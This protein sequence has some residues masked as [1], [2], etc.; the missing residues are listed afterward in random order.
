MESAL[1]ILSTFGVVFLLLTITVNFLTKRYPRI[2]GD[3]YIQQPGFSF[4][5]PFTSAL[6]ITVFL[7]FMFNTF[8]RG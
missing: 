8:F 7:V 3:I 4:F 1:R 5:L 2:P 6:T